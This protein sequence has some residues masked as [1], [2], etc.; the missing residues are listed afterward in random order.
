M[1]VP[2]CPPNGMY[3]VFRYISHLCHVYPLVLPTFLGITYI[4][5]C[6]PYG[7]HFRDRFVPI[8]V[9]IILNFT[10]TFLKLLLLYLKDAYT[11]FI[12]QKSSMLCL[13]CTL[14]RLFMV[15][16]YKP[17]IVSGYFV[18]CLVYILCYFTNTN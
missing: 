17:G 6:P 16:F 10:I 11:C 2:Y 14:R 15:L 18:L 9:C 13:V 3:Q 4:C 7:V 8:N 1:E 12:L 5:A